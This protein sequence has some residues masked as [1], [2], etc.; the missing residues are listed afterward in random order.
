MQ[1]RPG[2]R[3][4]RLCARRRSQALLDHGLQVIGIDPAE[5]DPRVLAAHNFTHIRK[6]GADV[7]RREFR[8]AAW[9]AAD[10][11]VAPQYTLDTVEAIV[12]HPSVSIRG[13]LLTLKLLDGT[14]AEQIPDYLGRIAV[15]AIAT[16]EPRQLAHNRQEICIAAV[17]PARRRKR[18]SIASRRD[19]RFKT[20][21]ARGATE[22][23]E[24]VTKRQSTWYGFA[25]GASTSRT[26]V[27]S[28]GM[29]SV[30]AW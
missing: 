12:T 18:R 27:P 20:S 28:G 13:L 24:A 30:K 7:R 2:I 11:N 16:S 3:R 10:M 1:R 26:R 22:K 6:R 14:L 23:R 5:V 8:H 29:C 15:G 9:L 4:D 17:R 25:L 21:K 19:G